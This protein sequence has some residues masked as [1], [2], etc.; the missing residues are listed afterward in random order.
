LSTLSKHD[1]DFNYSMTIFCI[2]VVICNI[3]FIFVLTIQY[4]K[5]IR[6][7]YVIIPITNNT[8][9]SSFGNKPVKANYYSII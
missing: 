2:F 3:F 5:M 7:E 9:F 6:R 1:I 8:Y 4:N